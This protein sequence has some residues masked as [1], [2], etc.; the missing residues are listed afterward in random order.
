MDYF[1]V[2][3]AEIESDDPPIDVLTCG[4]FHNAMQWLV[5]RTLRVHPDVVQWI[6]SPDYVAMVQIGKRLY[7]IKRVHG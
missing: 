1:K 3:S 7:G 2:T 4:V 6:D 5:D